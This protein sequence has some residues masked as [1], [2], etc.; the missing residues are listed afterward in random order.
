MIITASTTTTSASNTQPI[1]FS[2]VIAV[3]LLIIVS[4]GIGFLLIWFAKA[5]S[6]ASSTTHDAPIEMK[7]NQAY[8]PV[9]VLEGG[10]GNMEEGR[11]KNSVEGNEDPEYEVIV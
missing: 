8:G 7:A 10:V 11:H 1:V 4:G 6:R 5:K 9:Q 3:L 2:V